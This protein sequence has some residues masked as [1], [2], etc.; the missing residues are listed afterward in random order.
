MKAM[1]V[2]NKLAMANLEKNHEEALEKYK[3]DTMLSFQDYLTDL[4]SNLLLHA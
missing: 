2:Q 4:K 1:S 3:F